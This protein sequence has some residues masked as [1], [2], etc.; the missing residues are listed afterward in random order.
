MAVINVIQ[1]PN[2]DSFN[3]LAFPDQN[4]DTARYIQNQL[5][6]FSNTLTDVGL[7]FMN[8]SQDI[9]KQ[10]ND[11]M[12]VRAAKAAVR[13]AKGMFHPNV[14]VYQDNIEDIRSSQPIMQRYNMA[15]PTVR[16]LYHKQRCDGYSDTYRDM[17]PGD[18]KH[19][20][21]DYRRVMDGIIYDDVN[22][23]GEYTWAVNT[24]AHDNIGDDV[25]LTFDEKT[26]IISTWELIEMFMKEGE[27]PTDIYENKLT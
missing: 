5:T 12:S 2:P 13:R 17:H 19:D 4:P 21:Y 7:S 22:D 15:Q 24:Y 6:N 27:D 1:A 20:H 10:I 9:Y 11:S 23:E 26:D 14:I 18:I 16:E 25:D 8:A 3:Y